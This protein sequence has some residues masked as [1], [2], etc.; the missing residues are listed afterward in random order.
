[1]HVPL[2]TVPENVHGAAKNR[3]ISARLEEL[4]LY[5][6]RKSFNIDDLLKALY[7]VVPYNDGSEHTQVPQGVRR[8]HMGR[9][10]TE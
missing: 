6:A 3:F 10:K 4:L 7:L 5:R 9:N 8:Q 2:Y 1:M